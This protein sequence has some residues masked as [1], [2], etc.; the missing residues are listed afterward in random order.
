MKRI[1]DLIL[2]LLLEVE[3]DEK[4]DLS[5]YSEDQQKHHIAMVVK[6]GLAEGDIIDDGGGGVETAIATEL[7]PA[8]HD[9]LARWRAKERSEIGESMKTDIDVFV[10]HSSHDKEL[11]KAVVDLLIAAVRIPA[12]KIRCTTL[13][14]HKLHA[15]AMTDEVLR[16]EILGCK[17][18][19][20]LLTPI[21]RSSAFVLFELGARWGVGKTMMPLLACG[22]A[23]SQLSEPLKRA[24]ALSLAVEGDIHQLV[25]DIASCL[26]RTSENASTY[27][28][29]AKL[30]VQIA[31][32]SQ[33]AT[34]IVTSAP[35][36]YDENDIISQIESWFQDNLGKLD[37]V[38]FHFR[39]I[40][41]DLGLPRGSAKKHLKQ[42][43]AKFS[44]VNVVR[45]GSETILF[46][47]RRPPDTMLP[48]G[49]F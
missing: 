11:A 1:D 34:S 12:S 18:L 2:K 25:S 49:R 30:I 48:L 41:D 35:V 16:A 26:G 32:Q 43:A 15:G 14:G 13:E 42:I 6:S 40:D 46:S 38:T 21:S 24:N 3:G 4:P 45:E 9:Y 36:N 8:G 7:T 5:G 22:M 31:S 44:G 27:H 19:I 20:G 47:E 39:K 33:T 10:S 29:K 28:T 37:G 23:A 17:V